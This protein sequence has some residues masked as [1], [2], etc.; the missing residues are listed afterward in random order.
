MDHIQTERLKEQIRREERT[1][2]AWTLKYL[3]EEA[4]SQFSEDEANR[5]GQ[6][7]P[8]EIWRSGPITQPLDP[9]PEELADEERRARAIVEAH[10]HPVDTGVLTRSPLD[11]TAP[12]PEHYK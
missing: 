2:E 3:S 1:L 5:E 11:L 4:R 9:T 6:Y 7:P 12:L 10:K 8:K